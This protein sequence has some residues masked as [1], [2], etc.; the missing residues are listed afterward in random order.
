MTEQQLIE[1]L[2]D[3]LDAA[4]GDELADLRTCTFADAGL[5]ISDT[6]LILDLPGGDQFQLTVVQS[7]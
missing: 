4:E 1:T 5:L 7:R 3:I 2:Q 6:G